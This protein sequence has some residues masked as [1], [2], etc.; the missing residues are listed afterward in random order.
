MKRLPPLLACADAADQRAVPIAERALDA[1]TQRLL[2]WLQEVCQTGN[3]LRKVNLL[4][5]LQKKVVARRTAP[6]SILV[7]RWHGGVE[8]RFASLCHPPCVPRVLP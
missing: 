4:A 8:S 6:A 7:D 2:G 3:V 5:R 1:R